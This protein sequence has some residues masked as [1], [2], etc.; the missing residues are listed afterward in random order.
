MS[1]TIQLLLLFMDLL[2]LLLYLLFLHF[3]V[4]FFLIVFD[5]RFF[6]FFLTATSLQNH[7]GQQ[8]DVLRRGIA[9]PH[10][11]IEHPTHHQVSVS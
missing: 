1:V 3:F 6:F 9:L 4:S 8:N 2:L 11:N 10:A 5:N 7:P